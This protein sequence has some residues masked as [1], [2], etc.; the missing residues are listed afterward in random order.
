MI[1]LIPMAGAGSRFT[2]AGYELPKPLVDVAGEPMIVRVLNNL[3]FQHAHY[4]FLVRTEHYE[5]HKELFD[6]SFAPFDHD[7]ILVDGLTEGAACTTLLAEEFIDRDVPLLIANSDQLVLDWDADEF[8]E[9]TEYYSKS[10]NADA[11]IVTFTATDPKWS[12]AAVNEDGWVTEVAEK[13]P[14]SNIATVGMY[15]WRNGS[16][17]VRYAKQM[18]DKNRRVNN[19]F[20]VCPVFNEAIDDGKK[21]QT[22]TVTKMQGLGT[23]EDLQQYLSTL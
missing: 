13:L 15:F 9:F 19:E 5:K 21:I 7:I 8:L 14:I 11:C 22:Y 2:Q 10:W 20:Y 17:Y 1:V 18:I 3:D 12:F 6:K 16:D 4:V 23:P